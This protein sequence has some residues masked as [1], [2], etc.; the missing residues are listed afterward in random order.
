MLP[1][2]D[3]YNIQK[4]SGISKSMIPGYNPSIHIFFCGMSTL[5]PF[6]INKRDTNIKIRELHS[7]ADL[8]KNI[9]EDGDNAG[10]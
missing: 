2:S 6:Y 9:L 3:N 7:C 1:I 4:G 8:K 10:K 5:Q